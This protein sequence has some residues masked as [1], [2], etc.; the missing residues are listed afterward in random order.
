MIF[1]T[2]LTY[3]IIFTFFNEGL[4]VFR[5]SSLINIPQIR[6]FSGPSKPAAS[7]NDIVIPQLVDT[8]EWVVESPPNV[9][10]FDEPP[11]KNIFL[12]IY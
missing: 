8:L 11:V 12:D 4:N 6:S 7:T 3:T 9:H 1:Q 2:F 10:Q 5:Q